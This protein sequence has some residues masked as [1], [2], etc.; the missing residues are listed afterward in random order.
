MVSRWVVGCILADSA[1]LRSD[2]APRELLDELFT[3]GLDAL[4]D[5][6]AHHLD[7]TDS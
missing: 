4:H 2:L 6:L 7:P 1:M 5:S 3:Q